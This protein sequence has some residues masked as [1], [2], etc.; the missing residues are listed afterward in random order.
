[1]NEEGRDH[2]PLIGEEWQQIVDNNRHSDWFHASLITLADDLI[3]P[4]GSAANARRSQCLVAPVR[5]PN[6]NLACRRAD[7]AGL[8]DRSDLAKVPRNESDR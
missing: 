6:T 5:P 3:S 2:A 8:S 4:W 1:M 7:D